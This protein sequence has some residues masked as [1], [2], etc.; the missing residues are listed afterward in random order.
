MLPDKGSSCD[1]GESRRGAEIGQF[2]QGVF[3]SPVA[4]G[5]KAT[6]VGSVALEVGCEG[7]RQRWQATSVHGKADHDEVSGQKGVGLSA[8]DGW[9]EADFRETFVQIQ[10][11]GTETK[12]RC[13]GW[14]EV[15]CV[16]SHVMDA[17]PWEGG[18]FAGA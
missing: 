3:V 17:I 4:V 9:I 5:D 14:A 7:F 1:D 2:K 10:T 12:A 18:C 11:D 8:G 16:S 15:D 6:G 13:P